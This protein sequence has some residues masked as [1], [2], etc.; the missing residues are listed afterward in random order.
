MPRR[1]SYTFVHDDE[2]ICTVIADDVAM[3]RGNERE[4]INVH[5]TM[6]RVQTQLPMSQLTPSCDTLPVGCLHLVHRH[7]MR[8]CLHF[9]DSS[10]PLACRHF[11]H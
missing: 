11:I 8:S 2:F 1:E 4:A 10:H 3:K 7:L 9:T 6:M 5:A